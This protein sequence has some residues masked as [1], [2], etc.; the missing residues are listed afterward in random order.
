MS[1]TNI[2][3][4]WVIKEI[5]QRNAYFSQH[6]F[7]VKLKLCEVVFNQIKINYYMNIQL[8]NIVLY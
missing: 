3:Y 6:A 7:Q 1:K 5:Y 8:S 4:F 2:D